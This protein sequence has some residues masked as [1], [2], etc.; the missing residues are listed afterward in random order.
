M[1][2]YQFFFKEQGFQMGGSQPSETHLKGFQR[3]YHPLSDPEIFKVRTSL[4]PWPVLT[5]FLR[6][7][8]H[9]NIHHQK[10]KSS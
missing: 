10:K 7:P 1:T 3:G 5:S 4:K 2:G 6:P 9:W 8:Q